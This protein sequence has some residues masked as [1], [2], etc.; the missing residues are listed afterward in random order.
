MKKQKTTLVALVILALG[1][2]S[3]CT[4]R[5]G[6]PASVH[7]DKSA[8]PYHVVKKGDSIASIAKKYGMDKRELIR[9]NGLESPYRI[10]KGQ[11]LLVR[12][13]KA[14]RSTE[15]FVDD[16]DGP[17]SE[18]VGH[19]PEEDGVQ[20]KQLAPVTGL[21]S[22]ALN[23]GEIS[24]D[25]REN[26]EVDDEGESLRSDENQ[27]SQQN[28]KYDEDKIDEAEGRGKHRNVDQPSSM[29]KP[30]PAAGKYIQPAKG[31][32]IKNYSKSGKGGVPQHDGIT[33]A[34]PK[35][36]PVVAANNGVV[37]SVGNHLRG[38]GNVVLV[39][40][41][42]GKMTVYAHLEKII[43][44][45]GDVVSAGQKIGTVGQSGKAANPQLYFQ[46]REGTKIVDPNNFLG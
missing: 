45:K 9:T 18:E 38:Y 7:Y 23:S 39:K 8:S 22:Q 31:N 10:V 3:G 32:I 1:I 44:R 2:L 13:H 41:N 5:N 37:G 33:I 4:S 26:P 24:S 29:P 6:P 17:I 46:M 27:D 25:G 34:A 43:V 42:D 19:I 36:S 15:E 14:R 40:H 28:Q 11:R 12:A 30:P 35:G 21:A 16:S 20:V